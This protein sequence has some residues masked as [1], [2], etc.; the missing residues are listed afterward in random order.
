MKLTLTPDE[1][2]KSAERFQAEQRKQ[3]EISIE[4]NRRYEH[5]VRENRRREAEEKQANYIKD[6][7]TI[8]FLVQ[9]WSKGIIR[10]FHHTLIIIIM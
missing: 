3:I 6:N 5:R 7:P 2:L 10:S 9:V 1:I 4:A 8:C